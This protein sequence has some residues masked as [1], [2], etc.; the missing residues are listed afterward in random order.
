MNSGNVPRKNQQKNSDTK[1]EDYHPYKAELVEIVTKYRISGKN[2]C[3]FML[4]DWITVV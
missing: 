3:Q 1:I 4:E 2:Y